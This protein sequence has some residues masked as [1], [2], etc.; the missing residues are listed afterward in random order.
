MKKYKVRFSIFNL[1]SQSSA[2]VVKLQNTV[3]ALIV[4]LGTSTY[5]ALNESNTIFVALAGIILD[6]LIACLYFEEVK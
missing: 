2:E 3:K 4:T 6:T 1:F 5:L